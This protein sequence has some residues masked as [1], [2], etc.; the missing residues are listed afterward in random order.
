[1]MPHGVQNNVGVL[2]LIYCKNEIDWLK[3]TVASH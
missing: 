1:M 3:Q 2:V